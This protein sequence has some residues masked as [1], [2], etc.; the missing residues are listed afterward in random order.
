MILSEQDRLQRILEG[1]TESFRW[2]VNRYQGQAFSL[3]MA[4]L[5]HQQEAEEAVQDAFFQAYTGLPKFRKDARF[6]TWLFRIVIREAWKRKKIIGEQPPVQ[7]MESTPVYSVAPHEGGLMVLEKK[8]I[9][10]K[11]M[12]QLKPEERLVLDLHYFHEE[13][14]REISKITGY[15]VPHVKVLL[16]R[17]RKK[18]ASLVPPYLRNEWMNP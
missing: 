16:H 13:P 5:R 10:A 1:D 6:S 12:E 7:D 11:I 14:V 3:A 9:L 2:L 8:Q 15:H 17:A 18:L 4:V